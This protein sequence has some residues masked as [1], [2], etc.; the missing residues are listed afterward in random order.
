MMG[1]HWPRAGCG[2]PGAQPDT[3]PERGCANSYSSLGGRVR[4]PCPVSLQPDH[5]V[6]HHHLEG[7]EGFAFAGSAHAEAGLG[8]VESAVGLADEVRAILREELS[9]VVVERQRDVLTDVFVSNDLAAHARDETFTVLS[10]ALELKFVRGAGLEFAQ[11]EE[12][13]HGEV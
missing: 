5:A 1:R 12:A 8:F 7:L 2:L 11:E 10:A 4:L 9:I 6:L 3:A 13:L